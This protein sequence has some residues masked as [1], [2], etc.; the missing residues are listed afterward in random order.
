MDVTLDEILRR[1]GAA[2][3]GIGGGS[4]PVRNKRRAGNAAPYRPRAAMDTD[5]DHQVWG[6]A[7]ASK[8]KPSGI[9]SR[10]GGKVTAVGTKVLVGNLRHDVL[11]DDLQELFGKSTGYEVISTSI[12]FDRTGRSLGI[13][14]VVFARQSEAL[15]AVKKFHA[16]V[17]DGA[18][19]QVKLAGKGDR[20]NPN[21]PFGEADFDFGQHDSAPSS[22]AAFFGTALKGQGRRDREPTFSVNIGARGGRGGRGARKGGAPPRGGRGNNNNGGG[23]GGRGGGRGNR[24]GGRGNRP[25]HVSGLANPQ[26]TKKSPEELDAQMD[27]YMK[28]TE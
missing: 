24:Q 9:L 11:E 22:K 18:P 8:G 1:R 25:R 20:S 6:L 13:G 17:L 23:R 10:L 19:M 7:N 3:G 4:G 27:A 28:Q 16:R 5:E 14:E 26:G 2:A 21:D 15:E 12:K